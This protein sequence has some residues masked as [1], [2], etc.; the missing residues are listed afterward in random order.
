MATSILLAACSVIYTALP[1]AAQTRKTATQR[2]KPAATNPAPT[3]PAA[4]IQP[5][6]APQQPT[7]RAQGVKQASPP[8]AMPEPVETPEPVAEAAPRP[9]KRKLVMVPDFDAQGLPNWWGNWNI[10]S[11]FANTTVTHISRADGYGVVERERMLE[12]LREQQ[13]IQ[14]EE[15]RQDS[16]TKIGKLLGADMVLFGYLTTFSRN[17]SSKVIYDEYS[18]KISFN[19]RLVDISSGRIVK[20]A[21]IEYVSPRDRKVS[22]SGKGEI[23]PNSSDFLQSLFGKAIN[24]AVRQGV[25]KLTDEGGGASSQTASANQSSGPSS[26]NFTPAPPA[27]PAGPLKGM[28]AAVDGDTIVINRGSTHGVKAGNYFTVSKVVREIRDPENPNV[29]IRQQLEEL[30][31]I[32]VTK[33]EAASCDGVVVSTKVKLNERDVVVLV[34]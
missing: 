14:G 34:D 13:R 5:A 6:A 11:L 8:E 4:T 7:G 1:L 23:D 33:V 20:S 24:E 28:I 2:T 22:L 10:G 3:N 19:M 27:K 26:S 9:P 18:A 29:I 21:E 16:L 30:A 12:L 31:R 25:V 15:F 17:K 32:K